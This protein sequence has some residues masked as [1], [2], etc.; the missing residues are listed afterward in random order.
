MSR[1][2]N[3]EVFN[4]GSEAHESLR[5]RAKA[6]LRTRLL[7]VRQ[8]LPKAPQ[9]E[10]SERVVAQLVAHPLWASPRT[11]GGYVPI[12]GE[13]DPTAA[14]E[15]ARSQGHRV[16]LP[17]IQEGQRNPTM[18]FADGAQPLTRSTLGFRQ[19]G[20][21][22][23]RTP[24][25]SIDLIL[26]P[27]VAVDLRGFR[28]GYGGGYYDTFLS[29]VPTAVTVGLAYDFQL[30]PELPNTAQDV[31]LNFVVTEREVLETANGR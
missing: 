24:E 31:P 17:R 8:A 16:V 25:E 9:R 5:F 29:T 2:T 23:L 13:V 28:L 3:N 6:Q 20:A 14:L 27:L 22:A 12:R 1:H 26:V 7:A 19:P 11:I 18:H 4:P 15:R 21:E 30:L 10:R